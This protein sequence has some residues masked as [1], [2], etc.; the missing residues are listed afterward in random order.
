MHWPWWAWALGAWAVVT[1]LG[2]ARVDIAGR[3]L[4]V[5]TA[6]E[7]VVIVA[8]TVSG[9]AS[10][11]GGHLDL[12]R[13]VP[14]RA[15]LVRVRHVRG[16]GGDRRCWRSSGS[17]RPRCWPRRPETRGGPSRPPPTPRWARS[18][19]V[20]AGAAWAMAAHAGRAH[21]VAAAAA[22][23]PGL[24]FG[25]GGSGA[26][27]QAAQWLFLTSLFAAALAFTT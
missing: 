10:P 16:A 4:G 24:L 3:V 12:G 7:I 13:A 21:V 2:L 9:L 20:Y 23:G 8:E 11:A 22:Q 17:S 19:C 6:A 15:D 14:V 26:L 25:L 5:L 27:A 18:G 1:V